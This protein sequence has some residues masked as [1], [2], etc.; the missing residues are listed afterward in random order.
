LVSKTSANWCPRTSVKPPEWLRYP[1]VNSGAPES[2]WPT[3]YSTSIR[4]SLHD[5]VAWEANLFSRGK[6]HSFLR[7][8]QSFH[9]S[10]K[11]PATISRSAESSLRDA[12]QDTAVKKAWVSASLFSSKVHHY[13]QI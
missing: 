5:N 4:A 9:I 8:I 12:F 13:L 2:N 6:V 7:K 3:K 1:A 11:D 10:S